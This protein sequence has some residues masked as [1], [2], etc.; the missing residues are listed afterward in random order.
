M[1]RARA[2]FGA[3]FAAA[4]LGLVV[5]AFVLNNL[6]PYL[7]L[8]HVG[9]MTMYSGLAD[10]ADNHLLMPRV[11]LSGAHGYVA[12]LEVDAARD[13]GAPGVGLFQWLAIREE[14]QRPLVH[15]NVVRYQASRVCAAGRDVRLELTLQTAD[16]RRQQVENACADPAMLRYDVVTSYP[17]CKNRACRLALARWREDN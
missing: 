6:A 8:N 9:A 2:P 13:R 3:R 1:R 7:G 12:I 14:D 15:T 4:T 16:G 11:E 5:A 17:P 10:D